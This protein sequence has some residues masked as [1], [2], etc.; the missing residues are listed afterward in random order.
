VKATDSNSGV[1][2]LQVTENKRK[3]GKVLA[4]K[5]KLSLKGAAK[6]KFLRARDRAGNLSS[7]KKLRP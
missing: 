7:W 5:R 1:Q 4:Y 2:G 3:P 6:P